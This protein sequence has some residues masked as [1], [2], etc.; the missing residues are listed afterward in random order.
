MASKPEYTNS[1]PIWKSTG[2]PCGAGKRRITPPE[3]GSNNPTK[4]LRALTSRSCILDAGLLRGAENIE[5]TAAEPRTGVVLNSICT[6]RLLVAQNF[7]RRNRRALFTLHVS[8]APVIAERVQV[9]L[10]GPA[11]YD[12]TAS[13]GRFHISYPAPC[14]AMREIVRFPH[15]LIC[16][17]CGVTVRFPRD[18]YGRATIR[19]AVIVVTVRPEPSRS[20]RRPPACGSAPQLPLALLDNTG[21]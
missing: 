11:L 2:I 12:S 6:R 15:S 3:N 14:A 17:W 21:D 1:L 7:I 4:L 20:R 5:I 18:P 8:C 13:D 19:D 10:G 16:A 9:V